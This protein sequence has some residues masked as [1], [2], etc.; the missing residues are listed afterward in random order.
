MGISSMTHFSICPS[1]CIHKRVKENNNH[2]FKYSWVKEGFQSLDHTI[3]VKRGLVIIKTPTSCP[4][5]L[6]ASFTFYG[7]I[8]DYSLNHAGQKYQS[9][10][11]QYIQTIIWN[12]RVPFTC[13]FTFPVDNCYDVIILLRERRKGALVKKGW[14]LM[15]K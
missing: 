1:V 14:W 13:E 8:K 2:Y 15:G 5:Y 9:I 3:E 6:S 7:G 4:L 11:A 10:M 12:L